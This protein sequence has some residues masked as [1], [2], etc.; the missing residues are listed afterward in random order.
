MELKP[1]HLVVTTAIGL[2]AFCFGL[3][4][5]HL[6]VTTLDQAARF[7]PLATATIALFAAIVAVI[8]VLV[9]RDT[10]QRRAAIDFF[11]K[12]ETD[13]GLIDAY[14]KFHKLVPNIQTIM[15]RQNLSYDDADYR[16][17]RK[18]LNLCELIAVGIRLGG[19]SKKV[20]YD[21]WGYV[22]PDTY[23][24]SLALIQHIR[25]TP[26]LGGPKTFYDLE[27]L[28]KRWTKNDDRST[29]A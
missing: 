6:P 25:R 5:G 14:A 16:A 13:D 21:Y 24:Q 10:A 23:T 29:R 8:A 19:F 27:R 15:S 12:T 11:L 28:A 22:L 18:W 9:Q 2:L 7:A 3:L 20:S 1:G 4:I 17:L 26:A